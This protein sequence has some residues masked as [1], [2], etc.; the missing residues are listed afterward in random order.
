MV[1]GLTNPEIAGKLQVSVNTVRHQVQ[2]IFAKLDVDNRTAAVRL[3]IEQK[4]TPMQ[5]RQNST[6]P[7]SSFTEGR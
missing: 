5:S 7:F 3:A 4:L 6:S 1:D 2:S